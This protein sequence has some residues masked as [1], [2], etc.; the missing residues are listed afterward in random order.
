VVRIFFSHVSIELLPSPAPTAVN[1]RFHSLTGIP[2]VL[3][4][5]AIYQQPETGVSSIYWIELD[6]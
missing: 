6:I 2:V 4:D 5:M 3:S 1:R